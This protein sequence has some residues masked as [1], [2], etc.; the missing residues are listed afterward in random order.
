MAPSDRDSEVL[1]PHTIKKSCLSEEKMQSP[2]SFHAFAK[3]P[4]ELRL[5]IWQLAVRPDDKRGIHYFSL[6]RYH[7]KP[8]DDG[9]KDNDKRYM[10]GPP[11]IPENLSSDTVKY[12]WFSGNRSWYQWDLGLWNASKESRQ[13]LLWHLNQKSNNRMNSYDKYDQVLLNARHGEELIFPRIRSEYD[14]ICLQFDEDDLDATRS[15]Q[16]DSLLSRLPFWPDPITPTNLAFEFDPNWCKGMPRKFGK[17]REEASTR[18]LVVR[19]FDAWVRERLPDLQIWLIDSN[20]ETTQVRPGCSWRDRRDLVTDF[21]CQWVDAIASSTP[22][23]R[24]AV[25]FCQRLWKWGLVH[26]RLQTAG[27]E[28]EWYRAGGCLRVLGPESKASPTK[29]SA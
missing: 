2:E 23:K 19:V 22:K 21:K 20:I 13:A 5:N 3:L 1:R 16:W 24:S 12:S 26:R 7:D 14:I 15:I 6:M 4:T 17:M 8:T 9:S 18:G 27:F 25:Y 29:P 11:R 10:A 28:A